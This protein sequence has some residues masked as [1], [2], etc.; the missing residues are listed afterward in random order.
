MATPCRVMRPAKSAHA[1]I[2]SVLCEDL[3]Q[4]LEEGMAWCLDRIESDPEVSL[5]WLQ[6]SHR[7]GVFT[8]IR[9]SCVQRLR[10]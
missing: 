2:E 9:R 8:S 4:L 1:G 3:V 7:H 10:W 5:F 6:L